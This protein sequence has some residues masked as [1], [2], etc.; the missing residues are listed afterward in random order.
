MELLWH[1][2]FTKRGLELPA[3][4]ELGGGYL[5]GSLLQPQAPGTFSTPT[6]GTQLCL[7]LPD[8]RQSP[9][10]H[11]AKPA[12]GELAIVPPM[13]GSSQRLLNRDHHAAYFKVSLRFP[14]IS[15]WCHKYPVSWRLHR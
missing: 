5:S 13:L 14:Q 9:H 3:G 12:T 6:L 11:N 8:G 4:T 10:T 1:L 2:H 15:D 7:L